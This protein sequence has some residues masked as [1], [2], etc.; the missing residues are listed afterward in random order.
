MIKTPSTAG[1]A[2]ATQSERPVPSETA[3]TP[4]RILLVD[5][6]ATTTNTLRAA[7]RVLVR[8]KV[9]QIHA[10]IAARATLTPNSDVTSSA[11]SS[12]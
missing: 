10:L 7:S 11:N 1:A 5:D 12:D 8:A 9:A 2:T 3:S 6:V 4:L